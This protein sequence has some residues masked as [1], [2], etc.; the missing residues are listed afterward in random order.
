MTQPLT[1]REAA[2]PDAQAMARFNTAM[3]RETEGKALLPERVNRIL[4]AVTNSELEV[5]VKAVDAKVMLDGMQKIAN[6]ITAGLVLDI[7]HP[8]LWILAVATV[9]TAFHRLYATWLK[10]RDSAPEPKP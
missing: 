7:L 8:I 3:A 6:R 5:K 4:D 9:L 2:L 1:L 10:L